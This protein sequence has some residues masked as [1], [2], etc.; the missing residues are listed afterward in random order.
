MLGSEQD[1]QLSKMEIQPVSQY[2]IVSSIEEPFMK[3]GKKL[4]FLSNS[5]LFQVKRKIG[6]GGQGEV[7][8]V[9]LFTR[10]FEHGQVSTNVQE[11]AAKR[12]F[13][14]WTTSQ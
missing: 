12:F 1:R 9:D 7:F 5:T 13:P 8:L 4:E 2:P 10:R 11:M 14:K 6:N 3:K